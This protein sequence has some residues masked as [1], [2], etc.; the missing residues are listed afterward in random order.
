MEPRDWPAVWRLLEPAIRAGEIFPQASLL[1][2]AAA[3]RLWLEESESV[4]V[5]LA[6]GGVVVGSYCLR[7]AGLVVAAVH[8]QHDLG[9]H[10]C[11]HALATAAARGYRLVQ[12]NLM[13]VATGAGLRCWQRQGFRLEGRRTRSW[14]P[15][16]QE[17]GEDEPLADPGRSLALRLLALLGAFS[18][19]MIGLSSLAPLFPSDPE[20][21]QPRPQ[22]GL[23]S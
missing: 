22:E 19:L 12:V 6:P 10:L 9:S 8:R 4:M 13:L 21:R 5:A 15:L 1:P 20:P 14:R 2:E 17:D 18:F 7:P 16:A 3:R 11:R 23:L